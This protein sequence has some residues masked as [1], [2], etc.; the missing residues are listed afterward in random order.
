MIVNPDELAKLGAYERFEAQMPLQVM[1]IREFEGRLKKLVFNKETISMRQMQFSFTRDYEDFE[2]LNNPESPLFKIVNSPVFK[3]NENDEE[4]CIQYLLLL[5][6]LYC[7][8]SFEEKSKTF[9]DVLQDGM[10]EQISAKDKDLED[11]FGRLIEI[12]TIWIHRWS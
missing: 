1:D 6:L 10:Q 4:I 7:K 11:C 9:Y 5:G 12:A 3:Q 8:G 2:D